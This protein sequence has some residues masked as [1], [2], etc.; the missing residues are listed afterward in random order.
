M[1]SI[2]SVAGYAFASPNTGADAQSSRARARR[3]SRRTC[4]SISPHLAFVNATAQAAFATLDRVAAGRARTRR[5]STYPNNGFGQALR[6]VAGAIVAGSRH[7]GLLGADRRLRHA[8]RRRT[9]NGPTARTRTLMTTLNDGLFA[10]Y[11]DLRNQGLLSRHAGPAVLR[12]RPA[13]QRERQQ[14]HRPRRRQRDDGDGRRCAR[15][16]STAPR[17][18]LRAPTTTRRSRT[19]ASDVRY[20]TDFRSVYAQRPRQLA[21]QRLGGDSGREFPERRRTSMLSFAA[22]SFRASRLQTSQ[23]SDFERQTSDF[24]RLVS[25]DSPERLFDLRIA[26][27]IP[28]LLRPRRQ[29]ALAGEDRVGELADHDL[30]R[31]AWRR[32]RGSGDASRDRGPCAK[33]RLVTGCGAVAFTGPLTTGV[34]TIQRTISIQSSRWIHDMYCRPD[35]SGPPAKNRNGR[36][37]SGSAP[38][39]RSRTMPVLSRTTRVPGRSA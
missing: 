12:V 3:A 33:W 31:E 38:P 23:T 10:F 26:E 5:R 22:S 4:P 7:E 2:P 15:R 37:I 1:P 6:T 35:P 16:A 13:H 20:E 27:V 8:R 36:I 9:P 21:G 32:Q 25:K 30:Q 24:H 39:D 34:C 19:T 29:D 28:V 17:P 11:R 18:N 14:R